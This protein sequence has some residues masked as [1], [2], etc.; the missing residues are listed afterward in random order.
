MSV[1]EPRA[2]ILVEGLSDQR[3]V[4]A[5]AVRRG[6][7]LPA[8]GISVVAMDGATNIAKFVER[9]GPS[10]ADLR[11]AGLYDVGEEGVFRHALER[12]GLGTDLTR[13]DLQVLGFHVCIADLED[14]LIRALGV[15]ALEELIAMQGELES[16][17]T[18][19]KQP[20]QRDRNVEAQLRRFMGTNSGRKVFYAP[21]IVDALDLDKVPSPLD[22]VLAH[23]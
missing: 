19:Q 16:F 22:R 21:V 15:E 4:E 8:E 10:G 14:E 11:L 7:D 1:I 3:A 20:A 9:Y 12:A 18:M 5:L 17:R 13:E 23:V 2:V 6:R